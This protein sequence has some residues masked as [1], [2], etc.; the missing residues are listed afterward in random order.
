MPLREGIDD[1]M[2]ALLTMNYGREWVQKHCGP[3]PSLVEWIESSNAYLD[4]RIAEVDL[5][6]AKL[7][8]ME[9]SNDTP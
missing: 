5:Q 1:A 9:D 4:R 2:I 8:A 3:Q 7:Y 6:L